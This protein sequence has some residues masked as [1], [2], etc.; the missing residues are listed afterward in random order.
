MASYG[1][2]PL[3]SLVHQEAHDS[4]ATRTVLQQFPDC[5]RGHHSSPV[6]HSYLC[7][8]E[9]PRQL[10]RNGFLPRNARRLAGQLVRRAPSP[11]GTTLQLSKRPSPNRR[12]VLGTSVSTRR[13]LQP[14]QLAYLAQVVHCLRNHPR[15]SLGIMGCLRVLPR[16]KA[17]AS[18][19]RRLRRSC[20]SGSLSLHPR[21]RTRPHDARSSLGVLR[22]KSCLHPLLWDFPA[23]PAWHC[24]G[25]ESRRVPCAT[26]TLGSLLVR[27]GCEF[28][29]HHRRSLGVSRYRD[30]DVHLSLG[31]DLW[32]AIRILPVLVRGRD[33]RLPR[34][35][36]GFVGRL[37]W[38]LDHHG[39]YPPGNETRCDPRTQGTISAAR[40]LSCR[41][42]YPEGQGRG[43]TP[44]TEGAQEAVCLP[45]YRSNCTVRRALQRLSIRTV[46]PLQLGFCDRLRARGSWL[47]HHTH[48]PLLPRHCDRDM[49]RSVHQF[50][51]SRTVLSAEDQGEWREEHA[52]GED[53]DGES[54]R[55]HVPDQSVLVCMDELPERALDYPDSGE[56]ALGLEFLHVDLDDVHIHRGLLQGN[57]SHAS[58]LRDSP[59]EESRSPPQ[60]FSASAL[61]GIGFI[62]NLAGAGFPLFGS[63]MFHKLGNQG[64]VSLLA[65]LA[66]LMVPIPFILGRHGARLRERSP[67]ASMH[68]ETA[69]DDGP[70]GHDCD[71]VQNG[72]EESVGG[73]SS[74]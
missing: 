51:V 65:G 37:W 10:D 59:R 74:V 30:P 46:I 1:G 45:I 35:V 69:D 9:C 23:L 26:P 16:R 20:N 48:W 3:P 28:R 22:P 11:P 39:A 55:S 58:S 63:Q 2:Q 43:D 34:C 18:R 68:I 47:R 38:I 57:V 61:A 71:S 54:C 49:Y 12:A 19:V 72:D 73:T 21:S 44:C 50:L 42:T 13:P 36:L 31:R 15:R 25:A 6:V 52:G 53:H 67:W 40:R 4:K 8:V 56:R 14:A 64:A 41:A 66:C 24:L 7:L 29:G 32:L 70:R 60:T 33:E 27:H 62:R 5:P 17:N